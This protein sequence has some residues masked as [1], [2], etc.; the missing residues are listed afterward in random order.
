[1]A[2]L[3]TQ[4]ATFAADVGTFYTNWIE[5]S[6]Q[7][8]VRY[9]DE[10]L[11]KAALLPQTSSEVERLSARERTGDEL[12]DRMFLLTFVGG[13]GPE[14]GNT[15]LLADYL[16]RQKL[17]ATFFVLGNRLQQRRDAGAANALRQLYRG[18]CVGIQAGNTV[19]MPNGRAGRTRCGVARHGCR[20]TCRHSTCRCSGHRMGS[21]GPMARRS[22]PASN[23]ACRCGISMPW[24]MAR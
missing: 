22:W 14:G 24:T 23:C 7:F 5:P 10:Q 8:H 12:N 1:M 17:Q 20:L 3:R 9:L 6:H 13:P 16:R 11:R 19:P 15:D 21:A 4:A 18:Q 2:D